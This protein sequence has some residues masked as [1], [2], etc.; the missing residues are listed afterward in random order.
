MHL[1]V[2][3]ILISCCAAGEV[4]YPKPFRRLI[5]PTP[6]ETDD[7]VAQLAAIVQPGVKLALCDVGRAE[8]IGRDWDVFG[9]GFVLI[10]L[11]T[12]RP[13]RRKERSNAKDRGEDLT[14]CLELSNSTGE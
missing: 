6:T 10:P 2:F 4:C 13:I 9:P 5:H 1:I 7:I 3:I 8:D 14:L 12:G 11:G